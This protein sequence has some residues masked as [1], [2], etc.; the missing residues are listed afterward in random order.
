MTSLALL[1]FLVLFSLPVAVRG[2]EATPAVA[3]ASATDHVLRIGRSSWPDTFDPQTT[4][5]S[6]AV[7]TVAFERSHQAG[8]AAQ[9]RPCRSR[10][11]GIQR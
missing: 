8:R 2:Q 6:F 4:D 11:V 5:Y 9:H 3:S 7:P 1:L 10:V